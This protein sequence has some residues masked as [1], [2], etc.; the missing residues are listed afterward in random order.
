[1]DIPVANATS[2]GYSRNL[3]HPALSPATLI[4]K[5]RINNHFARE[6]K[7]S[8]LKMCQEL[9]GKNQKSRTGTLA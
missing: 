6:L 9:G 2:S 1:M 5:K 7:A 3:S 8:L 4:R